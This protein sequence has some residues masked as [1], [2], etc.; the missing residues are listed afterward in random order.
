M[1]TDWVDELVRKWAWWLRKNFNFTGYPAEVYEG[2][3]DDY[4]D[5]WT[6]AFEADP[7][8]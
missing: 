6:A 1:F 4:V 3:T 5:E 2:Y 7:A 8:N